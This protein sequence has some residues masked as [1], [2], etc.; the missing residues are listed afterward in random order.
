[1]YSVEN[2]LFKFSRKIFRV[3]SF[4]LKQIVGISFLNIDL[5]QFNYPLKSLNDVIQLIIKKSF[6]LIV[7]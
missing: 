3:S 2:E 5:I 6:K 4:Y 7:L 1:M